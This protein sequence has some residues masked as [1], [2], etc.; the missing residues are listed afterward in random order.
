[1]VTKTTCFVL[2]TLVFLGFPAVVFGQKQFSLLTGWGGGKPEEICPKAAEIGFKEIIV[3]NR[4]PEY[5]RRLVAVAGQYGIGVYASVHL[6]DTKAWKKRFP[7]APPPMQVMSPEEE[8]AAK[9]I[10]AD[11]RPG[12]G[13]YQFGGEP[14]NKMEVLTAEMFC[15]HRPEVVAF[16]K[17]E[18]RDALAVEG[19]KGIAF[20]YFGYRNY[21]CC[22]CEH[23]MNMFEAFWKKN[24]QLPREAA[25]NKFSLDTLVDFN[26]DLAAFARSVKPG[27]KVATHVYPVF[28]PEPLYGNRLDVDLCGQTAAWYFDPFWSNEKIGHYAQVIA[29][30]AKEYHARSEGVALIGIHT[31]AKRMGPV[32]TPERIAGELQAILDGGCDK[33]QVCSMNSVLNDEKIAAV[34]RRFFGSK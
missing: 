6:S 7:D 15:F 9:R 22:R 1:M 5:L 33:V 21:R 25:L 4:E 2:L 20:D 27:M 23:S 24:P 18:I 10:E 13:Q 32:K 11:T 34:F 14:V 3:W 12:K 8:A 31:D 30:E 17:E 26:N 28:L 16:L 29:G 19:L